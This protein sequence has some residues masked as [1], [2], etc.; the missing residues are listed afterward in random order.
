MLKVKRVI[1]GELEENCYILEK[2]G[3][4]IIIDP[5]SDFEKIKK[6]IKL[7]LLAV[8]ITHRH[9]DHI[10]ALEDV[11]NTYRC[12]LFDYFSTTEDN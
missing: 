11:L 5:G 12:Q 2:D 10:G 9:K 4:S 3:S 8:L 7:P 6:E 1:T